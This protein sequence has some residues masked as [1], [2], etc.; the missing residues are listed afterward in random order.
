M[1]SGMRRPTS[2]QTKSV[3]VDHAQAAHALV[4]SGIRPHPALIEALRAG[5]PKHHSRGFAL[6]IAD[7]FWLPADH[8]LAAAAAVALPDVV[9]PVRHYRGFHAAAAEHARWC[10]A[11]F[12]RSQ[13]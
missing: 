11:S 2:R 3:P 8:A 9:N 10:S 6:A 5:Y 4:R 1:S 7:S 12:H 13:V